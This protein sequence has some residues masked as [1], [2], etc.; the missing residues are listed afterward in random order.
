MSNVPRSVIVCDGVTASKD[1]NAVA[2]TSVFDPGQFII[3]CMFASLNDSY[4]SLIEICIRIRSILFPL[5][6]VMPKFHYFDLLRTCAASTEQLDVPTCR[7][8]T[9]GGRAFRVA[10]AK[11]WNSLPSDV[12]SA[13]SLSVFKNK[14]KT[15]CSAAA[16]K[17]FDF[18]D[19]SFPSHYLPSRTVVLAIVFTAR[20]YASA[21]LA[22]DL[23]PSV[24]VRLSVT[25]RSSTKTAKHRLTQTTPHDSPGTQ[26]FSDAKDL[27]E[28][29]PGS[30]PTRAPNAGGVGQNRRLLTNNRLYLEN[31]TR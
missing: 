13:S 23:C 17:L 29:R 15:Y 5:E 24:S 25:S 6:A 2:L 7:R 28:I 20:C 16:T 27:R 21:V 19:I 8:S 9:I 10:G 3:Y 14:L 26:L 12:T 18:N 22:M 11:V 30:P 31:G 1:G 4:G